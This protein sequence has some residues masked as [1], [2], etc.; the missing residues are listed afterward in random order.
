MQKIN[1][2]NTSL[3]YEDMKYYLV[4]LH[5][6]QENITN[7]F[8]LIFQTIFAVGFSLYIAI[9]LKWMLRPGLN[10]SWINDPSSDDQDTLQK[11]SEA[12]DV[13]SNWDGR[14]LE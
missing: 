5:H 9:S 13:G 3:S 4:L 8:H 2:L 6:L 7:N 10:S 12:K 14:E 1:G 11:Y